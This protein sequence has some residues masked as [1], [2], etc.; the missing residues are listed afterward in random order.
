MDYRAS[1]TD[2]HPQP[3]AVSDRTLVHEHSSRRH[4]HRD[5]WGGRCSVFVHRLL[6]QDFHQQRTTVI[7]FSP[8]LSIDRAALLMD[9]RL[10]APRCAVGL[11]Q[12]IC[13]DNGLGS[14]TAAVTIPMQF[15]PQQGWVT[16]PCIPHTSGESRV[17]LSIILIEPL[18]IWCLTRM[19]LSLDTYLLV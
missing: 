19:M 13:A 1:S 9:S 8:A 7:S 17:P 11:A 10:F 16:H 4:L 2:R 14:G 18:S 6:V 12:R 3:S 15:P 5:V